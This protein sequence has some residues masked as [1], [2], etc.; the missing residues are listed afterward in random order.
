MI[1]VERSFMFSACAGV[2]SIASHTLAKRF[3]SLT[4]LLHLGNAPRKYLKFKEKHVAADFG[5]LSAQNS[6][7]ADEMIKRIASIC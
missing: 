1:N 2:S 5:F 7:I 6:A 4:K 3:W